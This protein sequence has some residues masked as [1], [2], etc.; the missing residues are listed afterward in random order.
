VPGAKFGLFR[1]SHL[2]LLV[3]LPL[4]PRLAQPSAQPIACP[5]IEPTAPWEIAL[6]PVAL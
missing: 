6:K 5:G 4:L 3:S 2:A 1:A